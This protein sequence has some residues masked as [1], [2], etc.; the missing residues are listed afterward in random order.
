MI[1]AYQTG[2]RMNQNHCI[3]ESS[4]LNEDFDDDDEETSIEE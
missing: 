2:E 3:E 4:F 1:T